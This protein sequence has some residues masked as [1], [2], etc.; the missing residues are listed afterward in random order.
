M[1]VLGDAATFL[2]KLAEALKGSSKVD[3]EWI[4]ELSERE[5]VKEKANEEV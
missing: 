1:P 5:N 3:Q 4:S 2:V